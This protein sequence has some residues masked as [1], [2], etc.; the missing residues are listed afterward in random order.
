MSKV[1]KVHDLVHK[2]LQQYNKKIL[3]L[4]VEKTKLFEKLI[5]LKFSM[6]DQ[7]AITFDAKI[8][9]DQVNTSK[10]CWHFTSNC[11]NRRLVCPCLGRQGQ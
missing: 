3:H 6:E 9:L 1:I 11:L 5:K 7:K 8:P 4:E 2:L 10:K